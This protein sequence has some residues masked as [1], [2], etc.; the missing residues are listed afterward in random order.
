[1]KYA[2]V[3]INSSDIKKEA[4]KSPDNYLS[5]RDYT[6]FWEKFTGVINLIILCLATFNYNYLQIA[7]NDIHIVGAK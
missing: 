3:D 5:S 4:K 2:Y 1:M 6:R 7:N